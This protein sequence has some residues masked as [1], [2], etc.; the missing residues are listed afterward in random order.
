MR[1]HVMPTSKRQMAPLLLVSQE[2]LKYPMTRQQ[3]ERQQNKRHNKQNTNFVRAS[4]FLYISLPFLNNYDVR[5][6]NVAFYGQR[7]QATTKFHFS[8]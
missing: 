8:S 3:Q 6:L 1:I 4:R 7:K 5:M 2:G